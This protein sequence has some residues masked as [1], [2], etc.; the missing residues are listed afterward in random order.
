MARFVIH[1]HH[2]SRLHWD[3]RLEMDGVLKSWAVPK[4]PPT[5]TGVR[6]LAVE[7]EDHDL[8]YVDFEG[9]IEEGYGAGEVKIWDSGEYD[10]ESKKEHKIVIVVKGKKLNGRYTLL[11]PEWGQKETPKDQTSS[12]GRQWLFFRA[13]DKTNSESKSPVKAKRKGK[14]AKE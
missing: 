12:K 6:R 5:E 8:E 7:V 10:I 9:V 11:L 14:K 13:K 1:E 2:A 3:L 4:E